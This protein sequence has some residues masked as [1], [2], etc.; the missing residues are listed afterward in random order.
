MDDFQSE[1]CQPDEREKIKERVRQNEMTQA[2][3]QVWAAENNELPFEFPDDNTTAFPSEK[4]ELFDLQSARWPLVSV[5]V[6]IAT[7]DGSMAAYCA[8]KRVKNADI[9]LAI[10]R[11]RSNLHADD[12]ASDA[13]KNR[14][15]PALDSGKLKAFATR[16]S[17]DLDI[18]HISPGH[19]SPPSEQPALASSCFIADADEGNASVL[20]P[21]GS[22]F[23]HKFVEWRE[24]TFSREDVLK[25]WPE[26]SRVDANK[27]KRGGRPPVVDW[28]LVEAET[29]RLMDH[30]GDFMPG[31][32]K[33]N[34]QARLE[35]D[36]KTYCQKHFGKVPADSTLRGRIPGWLQSWAEEKGRSSET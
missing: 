16:A 7:R 2:E 28:S 22:Q 33:W 12:D 19:V 3:A 11:A 32:K 6:W 14:L 35:A 36:L 30:H 31:D 25:L 9:Y 4:I 24:L 15:A 26:L 34:A 20:H 27:A 8:T 23:A 21:M 18:N 1:D 13:W 10:K 29:V 5:L 17:V